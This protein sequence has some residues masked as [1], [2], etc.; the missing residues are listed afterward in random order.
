MLDKCNK[1]LK[2]NNLALKV[3]EYEKRRNII[4]TLLKFSNIAKASECPKMC[5]HGSY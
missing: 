1:I 2:Q 5:L 3:K 4:N